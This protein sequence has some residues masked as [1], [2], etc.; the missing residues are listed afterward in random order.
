MIN[1]ITKRLNMNYQINSLTKAITKTLV[2]VGLLA[3]SFILTTP[4]VLAV[5]RQPAGEFPITEPLRPLE[6][7]V[8][9]NYS[10]SIQDDEK[11]PANASEEDLLDTTPE[12]G[13]AA[14]AS[15]EDI[16]SGA[17]LNKEIPNSAD[18]KSG[19]K[20]FIVIPVALGFI[21]CG[22]I[23]RK[24][25]VGLISVLALAILLSQSLLFSHSS[26]VYAQ[27]AT[28]EGPVIQRTIEDESKLQSNNSLS[29]PQKQSGQTA[30]FGIMAVLLFV[31]AIGAAAM[32]WKSHGEPKKE[33]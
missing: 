29:T 7:N 21:I 9:P 28:R 11:T 1:L 25:I 13:S 18:S 10:N 26:V 3:F 33:P 12:S 22:F 4:S 23:W 6:G 5:A 31:V 24:K 27:S 16:N 15:N 19:K 30:I 14:T 32:F 2:V 8:E 20:W 17:D